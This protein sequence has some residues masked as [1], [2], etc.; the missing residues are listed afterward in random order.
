MA[1]RFQLLLEAVFRYP[2]AMLLVS[3]LCVLFAITSG[4]FFCNS[5]VALGFGIAVVVII[6]WLV[7]LAIVF[8]ND[9]P[10]SFEN[11]CFFSSLLAFP[12]AVLFALSAFVF[13]ANITDKVWFVGERTSG[14]GGYVVA[15][16][17]WSDIEGITKEPDI[18]FK[19]MATTK[20]GKRVEG[21]LK[22]E[23]RLVSDE[24]ALGRIVRKL[25]NADQ[26][27]RAEL[28]AHLRQ[29]FEEAVAQIDLAELNN[30]LVLEWEVGSR[31]DE[32]HLSA[33]GVEWAGTLVVS[34]LHVYFASESAG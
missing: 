20:D 5:T 19:A 4:L 32:G 13:D 9:E 21:W 29:K 1:E 31:V 6:L 12:G 11:T 17:F 2:K 16:P 24:A 15:V 34:D 33:L 27:I 25:T 3:L 23:I 10:A 26:V 22:P 30:G 18:G 28:E 7:A 14:H 8:W